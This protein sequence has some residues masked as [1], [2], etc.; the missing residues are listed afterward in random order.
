MPTIASG[1][2]KVV[3]LGGWLEVHRRRTAARGSPEAM[4]AAPSQGRAPNRHWFGTRPEGWLETAPIHLE[5]NAP[6]VGEAG[7]PEGRPVV[8]ASGV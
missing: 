2:F 7:R 4:P 5:M 3:V 8:T 1:S 6:S